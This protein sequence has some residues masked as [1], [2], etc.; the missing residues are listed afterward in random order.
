[1]LAFGATLSDSLNY[2]S[3]SSCLLSSGSSSF[4]LRNGCL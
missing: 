1:M 3:T 4:W 2:S